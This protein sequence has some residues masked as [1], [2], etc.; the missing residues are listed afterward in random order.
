MRV[1]MKIYTRTGDKGTT[2][3][4][5][6]LPNPARISGLADPGIGQALHCGAATL[7]SRGSVMDQAG[8]LAMQRS[9]A[10]P[11]T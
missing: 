4:Y 11:F 7:A 5:G 10:M 3:L 1:L 6:T 9:D 2:G 8:R